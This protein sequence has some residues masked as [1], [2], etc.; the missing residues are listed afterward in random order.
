[1]NNKTAK[2]RAI[3]Q[4]YSSI[5]DFYFRVRTRLFYKRKVV[6]RSTIVAT[7]Q[8]CSWETVGRIHFHEKTNFNK[9]RF[10]FN[11]RI[12]LITHEPPC[13]KACVASL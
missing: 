8:N 7:N 13:I 9:K 10:F 6:R 2:Y 3:R 11:F 5:P 12:E 4:S 1:M